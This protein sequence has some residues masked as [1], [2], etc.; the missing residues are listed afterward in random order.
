MNH[1]DDTAREFHGVEQTFGFLCLA[2][3]SPG[4]RLLSRE[5]CFPLLG[6]REIGEEAALERQG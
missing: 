5:V 2:Q 6:R 4:T 1:T 3:I